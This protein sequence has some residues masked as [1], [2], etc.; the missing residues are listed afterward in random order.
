MSLQQ[1]SDKNIATIVEMGF[2]MQQATAALQH[3]GGNLEVALNSLLPSDQQNASSNGQ[4]AHSGRESRTTASSVTSN[5]P[6]HRNDRADT[7]AHHQAADSNHS[8][9]TGLPTFVHC[10]VLLLAVLKT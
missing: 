7:R 4:P 9:R 5:G 6:A 10:V 2:S 3:S 1:Q 8:D